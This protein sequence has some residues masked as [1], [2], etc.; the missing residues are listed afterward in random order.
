MKHPLERLAPDTEK[1]L[2]L[3]LSIAAAVL[4]AALAYGE[5]HNVTNVAPFGI[6]SLQLAGKPLMSQLIIEKWRAL[7]DGT[8]W[9][10]FGLYTDYAFMTVYSILL[11]LFAL[12]LGRKLA[13]RDAANMRIAVFVAWLASATLPLDAVENF[14][15]LM[16]LASPMTGG[17]LMAATEKWTDIA[18]TCALA[19]FACLGA[20]TM[21]AAVSGVMLLAT[22]PTRATDVA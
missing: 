22:K 17:A 16:M 1:K 13:T 14:A 10:S 6:V 9:V 20:F 5:T 8:F 19:K 11:A 15:H 21:F 2:V 3:G 12:R 7:A 18:F 4:Y